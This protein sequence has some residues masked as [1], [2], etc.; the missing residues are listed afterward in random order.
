MFS[1]GLDFKS[2][3]VVLRRGFFFFTTGL[4]RKT[5]QD[6]K[7]LPCRCLESRST[8]APRRF[9]RF[10]LLN[11]FGWFIGT[12]PVMHVTVLV[13]GS[14]SLKP[15]TVRLQCLQVTADNTS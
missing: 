10:V 12:P 3:A 7:F 2:L 13:L 9:H 6:L 14:Q 1:E 5:H 15:Q 11:I 4:R 8:S